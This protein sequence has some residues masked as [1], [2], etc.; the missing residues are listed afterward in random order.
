M[1]IEMGI[2]QNIIVTDIQ[3][4]F[5]VN[6]ETGRKG[7]MVDRTTYGLSL[8]RSGQITYTMNGKS[9]ISKPGIA[10]LLPKGGTYTLHGDK[11]GR[12]PVINFQCRNLHCT[13]IL[14]IPLQDPDTCI[15]L[16]EDMKM[17]YLLREDRLKAY[18]AFYKL[19]SCIDPDKDACP[20]HFLTKHIE[21]H[22]ADPSLSNT[23]LAEKMGI[24]EVYLRKL[25]KSYFHQTPKQYILDMRLRHAK[26]L[27]TE[28][29]LSVT[30]VSERCGF[31]SV[32]HFCRAFKERTG[33]TPTEF[34]RAHA[35][36]QI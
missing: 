23:A 19:L 36:F 3:K 2:F 6:S 22:I 12:F 17:L 34:A 14:E 21:K 30:E 25:F 7:S 27:L 31:G 8:C 10:V 9:Y 15:E 4:P 24:S 1:V 35:F 26:Q 20:L 13:Q 33:Q 28:T 16:F 18:A 5:V 32:Y 29:A 11:E